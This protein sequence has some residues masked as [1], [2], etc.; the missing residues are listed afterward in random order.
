MENSVMH[1]PEIE[2]WRDFS[3][4]RYVFSQK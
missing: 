1:S 3:S 2:H 4:K